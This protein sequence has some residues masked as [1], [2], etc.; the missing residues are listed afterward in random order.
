MTGALQTVG[1]LP[2]DPLV[3]VAFALLAA[4]VVF[5]VVPL[6]PGPVLSLGGA[7]G[8]WW[9]TGDPGWLLLGVVL[10]VG[11]V[12]ALVDWFGGAAAARASGVSTRISVLAGVVGLAGTLVAGPVGLLV[13]IAGTVFVASYAAEQD[14]G[15][16]LRAA[17]YATAGVLGTAV[18]QT[19][20]TGSILVVVI[21]VHVL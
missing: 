13:G 21:L 2:V 15:N 17:A 1:A 6:L 5:S 10:L 12:A 9:A 4:G 14:T 7:L 16:S 3:L 8:Y 11:V 20:L 19:L 18:V